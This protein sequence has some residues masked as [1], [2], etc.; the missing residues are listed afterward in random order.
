MVRQPVGGVVLEF[1]VITPY[2]YSLL[3]VAIVPVFLLFLVV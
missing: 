1:P 2:V 3:P